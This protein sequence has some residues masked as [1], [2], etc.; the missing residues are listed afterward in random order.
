[1][2]V[3]IQEKLFRAEAVEQDKEQMMAQRIKLLLHSQ[4]SVTLA[5]DFIRIQGK[6]ECQHSWFC[7][8][9]YFLS[10]SLTVTAFV[11]AFHLF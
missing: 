3:G 2:I 11:L 10:C 7:A 1:M 5:N 4:T 9:L 6:F 8:L